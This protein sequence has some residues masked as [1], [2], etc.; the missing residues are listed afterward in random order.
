MRP[1]LPYAPRLLSLIA[2]TALPILFTTDLWE[3]VWSGSRPQ[4]WDGSGHYALAQQYSREIFPDTFGWTHAFL[5]GT[6]HPNFYPPLFYWLVA[7]L[8]R[9]PFISFITSFKIVLALPLLLLPAATW[10]LAWKLSDKD[11][12]VAT[13][14]SVASVPLL[15]DYNFFIGAAPLGISYMST[16]LTGLYSHP[17]G[18]LLL[19]LWYI[20]YSDAQQALWRMAAASFLL[21]LA[22]LAS[23]FGASVIA[24]FVV[25]TIIHDIVQFGRA[26]DPES[27]RRCT[28]V[29]AAHFISP[30][31]AGC[32]ALFWLAPVLASRDYFVTQPTRVPLLDL[33]PA[34]GWV[35]YA[36]ALVGTLLWLRRVR[37]S[38]EAGSAMWPYLATCAILA[39]VIVSTSLIEPRG[40]PIYPSR[41][42][43]TL[44]FLLAVPVGLVF[45]FVFKRLVATMVTGV[46]SAY[47][48][49]AKRAP[50]Y[51]HATISGRPFRQITANFLL[52]ATI[53]IITASI[54]IASYQLAFYQTADR[55]AI[56]PLL[57]FA[58]KHRD[59]RY[60]VENTPLSDAA[61]GHEGRAINNFLAGQGNEVMSLFFREA[62]PSVIFF[63]PLVNTFSSQADPYGI[64]ATLADDIDFFNQPIAA[65]LTQARFAGVRYLVI[66]S[67]W[68]RTRLEGEPSITARHDFGSWSIYDLGGEP[69]RP[70]QPLAYKP[71][72]VV[73]GLNFK[74]RRQN[75]YEFVRFAEEQFAD[76]RY[77]VLLARSPE[78]KLDRL[79]VDEGFGA[80]VIDTY[81]Y[82][83][84]MLAYNRLRA[85]AERHP[86]LLLADDSTLR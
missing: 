44:N 62:S 46:P 11:R 29:L 57:Q 45:A 59:G 6:P 3:E 30:L 54:N 55:E 17:L 10:L 80:L 14:A 25:T 22:L 66:R 34:A 2:V 51:K 20:V 68:A 86:L 76:G 47:E 19:V 74:G 52:L 24:L 16:F 1:H 12:V 81:K 27:R 38:T 7:L 26:A 49:N 13:C 71:A 79:N 31:V 28:R 60:L 85:L 83:D 32:L 58:V 72:L 15:I 69:F 40:F 73:S 36:L 61:T 82:D 42:V 63:S 56:D 65:H 75:S 37:Q 70:V 77:D 78:M 53:L 35:W 39:G 43:A 41:L 84:E 18:H 50:S 33:V 48:A 8:D 5:G 64:S 4:A 9:V 67:P 21:A 23:L